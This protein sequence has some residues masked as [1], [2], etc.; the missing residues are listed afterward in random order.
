[1]REGPSSWSFIRGPWGEQGGR[2]EAQE[3]VYRGWVGSGAAGRG[4]GGDPPLTG[5][6]QILNPK[7]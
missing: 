3:E 6:Y 1:M 2:L 4:R 7:P 5:P